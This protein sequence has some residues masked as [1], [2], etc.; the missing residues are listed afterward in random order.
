MEII[1]GKVGKSVVLQD[2]ICDTNPDRTLIVDGLGLPH[3]WEGRYIADVKSNHSPESISKLLLE[4]EGLADRFD[5][6]VFEVNA[7]YYKVDAF[8]KIENKLAIDCILTV[9]DDCEVYV[10]TA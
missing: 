2:F 7:P 3:L 6:I 5:L 9:Q 1:R 8:K 4:E 10:Y